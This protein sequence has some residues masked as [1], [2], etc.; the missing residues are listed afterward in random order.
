[1]KKI[2]YILTLFISLLCI[3]S[4]NNT[5]LP[6]EI[7]DD[8]SF[9]VIWGTYGISSYDS[10]TGTLIKTSDAT[11]PE[12]YITTYFLTDDELKQI[13]ELIYN[14]NIESY[15]DSLNDK[16]F[17]T[18][19]PYMNLKLE[20]K[21]GTINKT[22]MASKVSNYND[23]YTIKTKKYLN[24]IKSIRDI[25]MNTAEWKALPDYEFLYD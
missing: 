10:E 25:L 21:T 4:C 14:L 7:P 24:V 12:D 2:L 9:K 3:C 19:N 13:Y 18:S 20:V 1:M 6:K 5:S 16:S 17:G 23:G 8:F 15:A 22:I 11:N